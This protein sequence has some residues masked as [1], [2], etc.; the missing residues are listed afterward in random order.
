MR[1][2]A[3]HI[4]RELGIVYEEHNYFQLEN[5]LEEICRL[6]GKE[7]IQ[8][9]YEQAK[10]GIPGNFRQLLLDLATNNETSF[11]RD[12][13]VFELIKK[14]VLP[15]FIETHP[16]PGLFRVWSA[17]SSTGQEAVSI[18]ILIDQ[19]NR[20]SVAKIDF[21]ILG[22]DI[23]E[24]VLQRAKSGCYSQLEVQR[25]LSSGL[26]IEYFKNR[27][28]LQLGQWSVNESL[29]RR[30]RFEKQN[31]KQSFSHLGRFDLILCR[32]VLIYQNVESKAEILRRLVA[33][34]NEGGYLILGAG[35][36]IM[37]FNLDL[38]SHIENGV[39]VYRKNAAKFL[40]A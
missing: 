18:A 31:L 12:P 16:S 29:H 38:T 22:T 1:F 11:F 30:I 37:G 15:Q 8:A 10:G 13:K 32:N 21:S 4:M 33:N 23:S 20:Q 26:L 6:L 25:G 34:L 36:S 19:W 7:N 3:Q 28:D 27:G 5:R 39:I 2:F 14:V 17:A 9:L 40:A 35:E 24:R